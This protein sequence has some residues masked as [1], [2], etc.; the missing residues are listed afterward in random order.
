MAART[1]GSSG[2][3]LVS[4]KSGSIV[5]L[6]SRVRDDLQ[7]NFV[8]DRGVCILIDV[9]QNVNIAVVVIDLDALLRSGLKKRECSA[10]LQLAVTLKELEASPSMLLQAG[11]D[12]ISSHFSQNRY[13][14]VGI[15]R[16]SG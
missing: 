12:Q 16:A 9:A 2:R 4:G 1:G 5:D 13:W 14:N 10:D 6:L 7:G 11:A 8:I 3:D 15:Y